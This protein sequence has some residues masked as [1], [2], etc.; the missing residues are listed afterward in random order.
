MLSAQPDRDPPTR[1]VV[2]PVVLGRGLQPFSELAAPVRFALAEA[3]TF[4]TGA[5][6]HMIAPAVDEAWHR[7]MTE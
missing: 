5:P 1:L 2:H 3:I 7:R 4:T 6:S